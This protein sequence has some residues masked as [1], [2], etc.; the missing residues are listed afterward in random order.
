MKDKD[1]I[2]NLKNKKE[3][4]KYHHT[5]GMWVRNNWGLWGGSR[6][7]KYF[8]DKKVNH[9]DGMSGLIL[10]FYYDWLNNINDDWQEWSK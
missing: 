6:L 10:E 2:K 1:E 5:L 8:L 7:Q 9:P 4:I 3:T